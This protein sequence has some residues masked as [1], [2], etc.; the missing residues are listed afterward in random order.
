MN[1]RIAVG[2][3]LSGM[4]LAIVAL[5]PWA[6]DPAPAATPL[7]I[8]GKIYAASAGDDGK[9]RSVVVATFIDNDEQNSCAPRSSKRAMPGD[10][11]TCVANVATTHG[12]C[13]Q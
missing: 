12:H 7:E 11:T 6:A 8:V 3:M 2:A 10:P 9:Y 5:P 13:V 4:M 1:C